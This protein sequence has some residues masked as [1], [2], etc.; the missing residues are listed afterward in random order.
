MV[1]KLTYQELEQRLIA[2]EREF[3]RR[4]QVETALRENEDSYRRVV[5]NSLSSIVLYRQQ[6][7]LFANKPFHTMFGYDPSELEKLTIDDVMAPQDLEAVA[8]LRRRRLA[9]EIEPAAVYESRGKRK[10]GELFE[11]EISVCVVSHGGEPCCLAFLTD[12][13]RRKRVEEELRESE[14]RFRNLFDLSPNAV[15]LA[16]LETGFIVDVND[17]FC[18]LTKYSKDELIGQST[19]ELY[20]KNQ[21]DEFL[22]RLQSSGEVHGLEMDFK[23]K[24]GAIINTLMFSKII[25]ISG[26]SM[27]LTILFDM[28]EYKLLEKQLQHAQKMEAIGTLAGGVAHDFNNLLMA[29]Q[30]NASLILSIMDENNPAY[31]KVKNIEKIVKSGARLTDQLLG[32]AR[33]V[34][35]EIKLIDLNRV[36]NE[37]SE[38]FESTNP[39]M[40]IEKVLAPDLLRIEADQGQIEQVLLN[41]FAN[42]ADA[43]G[44]KGVLFLETSNIPHTGIKD[45][46]YHPKPGDYVGLKVA[47][48]GSGMN[49]E[50]ME[51]IFE[52]FFTTKK[53]GRGTGLGLASVFG[54]VKAHGGY[55]DV[56]SKVNLGTTFRIFIPGRPI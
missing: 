39:A 45:R 28:T 42:A 37:A 31:L 48:T 1:Q 3:S 24:E 16:E 15:G 56:D 54:I 35:Y 7:I 52:P 43:M 4:K 23:T 5:E 21:R 40:K 13:S 47:D 44:R 25:P 29:I 55:I 10:N 18:R 50:T 36:V 22:K 14:I 6:E 2:L 12:I 33:K 26:K 8:E 11:M 49:R 41:L 9:G 17:Q 38:A 51:R 27:I 46:P 32:Y 20:S 53:M 34:K 19:T 30:G